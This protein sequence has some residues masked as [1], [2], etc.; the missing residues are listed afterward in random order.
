MI[1]AIK[2]EHEVDGE[3]EGDEKVFS[4]SPEEGTEE[5]QSCCWKD[6]CTNTLT[7]IYLLLKWKY[8]IALNNSNAHD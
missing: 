5:C 8:S 7:V 1:R 3:E 6:Q 2:E 4:K